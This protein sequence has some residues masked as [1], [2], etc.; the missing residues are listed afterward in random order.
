M[1]S[2]NPSVSAV[3]TRAFYH[4]TAEIMIYITKAGLNEPS[5]SADLLVPLKTQ[6][7]RA[8]IYFQLKTRGLIRPLVTKN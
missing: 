4:Y 3:P 1:W 6:C 5:Q 8:K 7:G 2:R